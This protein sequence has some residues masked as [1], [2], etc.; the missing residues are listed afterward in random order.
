M[1]IK[2]TF[3]RMVV[4]ELLSRHKEE[5]L[6]VKIEPGRLP[7]PVNEIDNNT[8]RVG[9]DFT[10]I[11]NWG[12]TFA[13]VFALFLG[14]GHIQG[15]YEEWKGYEAATKN[16]IERRKK[17][18]GEDYFETTENDV[19]RK[20]YAKIGD[21]MVLSLEEYLKTT[22][23][24]DNR[25]GGNQLGGDIFAFCF[26]F[27]ILIVSA[28]LFIR[29]KRLAPLYFDREKQLVYT[30]RGGLALAQRYEDLQYLYHV[31]FLQIPLG[32][33]PTR[34]RWGQK[35]LSD[36]EVG[37]VPYRIMPTGPYFN[38]FKDYEQVLAYV[39]QFM[40]NG[41][42][43]VMPEKTHWKRKIRDFL[44]YEDQKPEDFEEQLEDVLRRLEHN[45]PAWLKDIEKQQAE[46]WSK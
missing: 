14:G 15:I 23:Y 7:K 18:Y 32:V 17:K 19:A 38:S 43:S 46:G 33:R 25:R 42:E 24:V 2:N 6:N 10:V 9:S 21:D 34:R 35:K 27:T 37:W 41:R 39:V 40:E 1:G 26:V 36:V 44:F 45:R 28:I 16:Y 30:W 3:M 4:P 11:R 22:R 29:F 31:Q 20:R 5:L 13:F 8:I 12:C